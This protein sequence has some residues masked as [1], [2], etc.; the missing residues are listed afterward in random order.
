[1]L[2]YEQRNITVYASSTNPSRQPKAW[3]FWY[4][5][6]VTF[7][8]PKDIHQFNEHVRIRF[9]FTS[10]D[11]DQIARRAIISKMH[12]DVE[13]YAL[14]WTIEP[15]PIDMVNVYVINQKGLAVPAIYP[16]TR[17]KL[18]GTATHECQFQCTSMSIA[19]WMTQNILCGKYKLQFEY[20]T[21]TSRTPL[22]LISQFNLN[23]L[24]SSFQGKKYIHPRQ[25]KAFIGKYFLAIQTIDNTVTEARLQKLF[26]STM[27]TIAHVPVIK[28]SDLWLNENIEQII[29]RD[30]FYIS[31]QSKYQILF[32]LKSADSP[33]F[34]TSSSRQA[35]N[36][37]EIQAMLLKQLRIHADWSSKDQQWR[38]KAMTGHLLTDV[39]D[40]LQLVL[41]NQQYQIDKTS[42]TYHQTI[43]CSDWSTTCV[44]QSTSSALVFISNSQF[45]RIPNLDFD[46]SQTGF[47]FEVRIRPDSLPKHANTVHLM[48]IRGEYHVTYQMRGEITFSVIDQERAYLYTTSLQSI[49]L[50]RWTHI[51]GVYS[52]EAKQL[53]LY[54][55]GEFVSSIIHN[56][57]TKP[58]N[59]D[60]ILGQEFL[61]AMRDFR[62]WAC[63]LTSDEILF[64]Q[65]LKTLNGNETCLVG[66]WPM[67]DGHGQIVA[68]EIIKL[69]PHPGTLGSDENPH[70]YHDPIWAHV[71]PE[72]PKP[73]EPPTTTYRMFRENLTAP[74]TSQWGSIIDL[75]VCFS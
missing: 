31:L 61:G 21:Q 60:I 38:I 37:T 55:N 28:Q 51:A 16:C 17:S 6:Y 73:P 35:F 5:P 49:P 72:L 18:S 54:I 10:S 65:K 64:S 75:P 30:L 45:I 70:L 74:F 7:D 24:R 2:T 58:I 8:F 33:W 71:L 68:D 29:N 41:I 50:D 46:F 39:L 52:T 69:L 27:N 63:A 48:N 3:I 23:S 25:E 20:Y 13:Q 34:L 44:C 56:K 12:A 22:P 32:H 43:D 26:R 4:D 66:L 19:Y 57:K 14:F 1:M 42:A 59:M 53:Q 36:V 11:F 40:H 67:Q 15:L 62:L 47:T 9:S